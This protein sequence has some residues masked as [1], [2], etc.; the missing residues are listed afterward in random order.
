M[1]SLKQTSWTAGL[2]VATVLLVVGAW[3]YGYFT[4]GTEVP[5]LVPGVIPG[6]ARV[7][8]HGDIYVGLSADGQ[9][10]LGYAAVGEA[11]GYGGPVD[12]LVGVSPSGEV[13]GIQLLKQ[14]ETPGFFRLVESSNLIS[15]FLHRQ[16][17]QPFVL[18]EDL[19]AV[20]GATF[21]SEGV[22]NS[23]SVGKQISFASH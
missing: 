14:R 7:E 22:A 19:D 11:P 5:P 6:A 13:I 10:I 21:S 17:D 16:A 15:Q 3:L 18:G 20:S 9:K 23:G 8:K 2:V 1:R 12:M 4:P